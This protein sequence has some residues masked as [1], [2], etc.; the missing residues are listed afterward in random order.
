M[1]SLGNLLRCH[2]EFST[3]A[4]EDGH[5]RK[6]YRQMLWA[7]S[8]RIGSG[9]NIRWP[10]PLFDRPGLGVYLTTLDPAYLSRDQYVTD[11][12]RFSIASSFY[13]SLGSM[14]RLLSRVWAFSSSS[15]GSCSSLRYLRWILISARPIRWEPPSSVSH[16]TAASSSA[17]IPGRAQVQA[18]ARRKLMKYLFTATVSLGFSGVSLVFVPFLT[19][20][21]FAHRDVRCQPGVG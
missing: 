9:S 5:A 20:L 17:P 19:C 16:T 6:P 3:R 1:P 12:F 14:Y 21:D 15:L 18:Y 4:Q 11:G 8:G 2:A 7:R 10:E 13:V